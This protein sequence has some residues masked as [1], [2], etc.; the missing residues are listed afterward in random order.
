[1][2]YETLK[3]F[4]KF[5]K[6]KWDV[7][8]GAIRIAEPPD[9]E[10]EYVTLDW[11]IRPDDVREFALINGLGFTTWKPTKPGWYWWRGGERGEP[12]VVQVR[13]TSVPGEL[14]VASVH[15][16]SEQYLTAPPDL[17]CLEMPDGQ[18]AGPLEPPA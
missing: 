4:A 13:Y 18:W 14:V 8:S 6:V 5:L 11:D 3:Q 9:F 10:V 1:M 12:V 7:S 16:G 15:G 2:T 17:H